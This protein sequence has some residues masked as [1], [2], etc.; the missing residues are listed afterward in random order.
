MRLFI[1]ILLALPIQAADFGIRYLSTYIK[2]SGKID[3][4]SSLGFGATAEVIWSRNLSTQLAG[5][6]VQ[7]AAILTTPNTDLGTIGVDV[8]SLM[9]RFRARD[10]SRF[11]PFAGAGVAAAFLGDLD[12]RFGDDI[13]AELETGTTYVIEAGLRSRV[14]PRV[15]FEVAAQYLPLEPD[16]R[17]RRNDSNIVLPDAV[18]LNP[19]V[20]SIGVSRRF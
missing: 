14:S 11:S 12:D 9:M 7:P 3:V 18:T 4:P 8:V 19:I 5:T 6:F 1:I 2:D 10:G 15:T 16:V 20:I 17:V 13:E